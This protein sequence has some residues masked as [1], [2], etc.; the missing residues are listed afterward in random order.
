MIQRESKT[1]IYVVGHKNPDTDSICSA[2]SYAYLKNQ[3]AE[4]AEHLIASS[5]GDA[6]DPALLSEAGKYFVGARAGQVNAET[7]F[8]LNR[9]HQRIPHYLNNIGTRVSDMEIHE[10]PGIKRTMSL[11]KAWELMASLNVV[12]LPVVN[13][14]D[15]LEGMITINDIALSYMQGQDSRMLSTVKTSYRNILETLDAEMIVGD[16]DAYY[17]EGEVEIATAAPEVMEEYIQQGDMV[18]TGNR[19]ESQLSAIESGAGCIIVCLGAAISKSIRKLAE[20][21]GCQVLVTPYDTY[22]VARQISQ[23]MPVSAFMKKAEGLKLFHLTDYTDDIKDTM[24]SS[25][26]RDFAVLDKEDKYV[27]MIS[28]RNFLGI[29]KR[30][31]ILVDHNERSQAVDNIESAVILE[32]IDHHRIGSLETM[33]PV[34]FRNEPIGCTAS[35]VYKIFREK[36]VEIIPDIAGLL[37]SAILSDTLI[38]RSPTCTDFDRQAA[39]AL[40]KIAGLEPE[41]YGAQMF[42]AGSDLKTKTPEEIFFQDY[43]RFEF[44]ETTFSV[45]QISSMSYDELRK[46]E[47]KVMPFLKR[48]TKEQSGEKFFLVL[49]NILGSSSR[50]VCFGPG[51]GTLAGEAFKGIAVREEVLWD[52]TAETEESAEASAM[53][54]VGAGEEASSEPA[55][56]ETARVVAAPVVAMELP[57][58]VSRK[59]QLIP[60]FM[61]AL[62]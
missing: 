53:E 57:G 35:I 16:P 18:I 50:L 38:F 21:N 41:T 49:T 31:I 3:L 7:M 22:R 33:E 11:K 4:R 8:V 36:N 58:L 54:A 60:R 44:G 1:R 25:R 9:F 62:N 30:E 37:L 19:Y 32:I 34:Y 29:K 27:G 26:T 15:R 61:E 28:R 56:E 12:T 5:Q 20:A 24:M 42:E 2:I 51:A 46:I 6:V 48:R 39:E 14:E 47:E 59:K 17:E 52:G 10:V 45:S 23:A 55:E 13:E 43:K 40:A